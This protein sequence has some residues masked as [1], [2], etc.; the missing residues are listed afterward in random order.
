MCKQLA[1]II[2]FHR[3][4][5]GFD[6]ASTCRN[7]W[8]WQNM[9]YE[10]ENGKQSVQLNNLL[11]I[12]KVL[13]IELTFQGP[14]RDVFEGVPRC[15]LLIVFRISWLDSSLLRKLKVDFVFLIY[16]IIQALQFRKPC[17][18]ETALLSLKVSPFF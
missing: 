12:L 13:N 2:L 5:S 10:L 7:G 1:N 16:L 18:Y 9:V 8:R 4:R 11:R 6:A 14:L 3:K 17:P 15:R